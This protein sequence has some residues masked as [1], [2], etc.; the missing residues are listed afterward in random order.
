MDPGQPNEIERPRSVAQLIAEALDMYQDHPLLFLTLALGVI[1]PYQLI[2]LAATGQG[3][4]ASGTHENVGLSYLLLL[5]EVIL[6]SP[7]V[8]ALHIHAVAVI[9]RGDQPR[10]G[11][12]ALCALK[13]LPVVVAAVIVSAF[14][15][16]LGFIALIV[17]GVLL[18]LGWAVVAQVA[19]IEHEGWMPSLQRSRELTRGHYWHIFWLLLVT[20][21]LAG[22][23]KLAVAVIPLGSS[24][25]AASVAVGI[26]TYTLTAS[27]S[28]LTLALLYYDLR[29]RRCTNALAPPE[30]PEQ[31]PPDPD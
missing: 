27:F 2:V 25:G 23:L 31:Q 4:L 29:G 10:L 18:T 8:S 3:P 12:V 6:I 13:V 26:L 1:A 24:S 14:L 19:A 7:L 15:T 21:L 30:P 5:L 17:P 20:G 9:G 22:G 28:A 11:D 16:A